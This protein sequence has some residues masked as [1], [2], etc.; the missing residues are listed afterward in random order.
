MD[1]DVISG[2]HGV[3]ALCPKCDS[4]L[5][6]GLSCSQCGHTEKVSVNEVVTKRSEQETR[7]HKRIYGGGIAD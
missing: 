7:D 2:R 3:T 1:K 4:D 5:F 6:D